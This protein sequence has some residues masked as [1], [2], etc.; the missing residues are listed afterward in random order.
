MERDRTEHRNTMLFARE[1]MLVSVLE[2]VG[3]FLSLP[4]LPR[5]DVALDDCFSYSPTH[6]VDQINALH[7]FAAPGEEYPAQQSSAWGL[8]TP[9]CPRCQGSLLQGTLRYLCFA[10]HR[11]R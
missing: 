6:C 8:E 11:A 1:N 3:I 9:G 10:W 4:R 7:V 5:F 2:M